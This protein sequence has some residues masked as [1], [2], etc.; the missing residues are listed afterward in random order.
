M[1]FLAFFS[2]KTV[3]MLMLKSSWDTYHSCS[4]SYGYIFNLYFWLG[5]NS[6]FNLGK[7]VGAIQF[8]HN[9]ITLGHVYKVVNKGY[10]H[11]WGGENVGYWSGNTHVS[12]ARSADRHKVRNASL[13]IYSWPPQ[14]IWTRRKGE[15]ELV[16][17][18]LYSKKLTIYS[19]MTKLGCV[20]THFTVCPF[21]C[22][23]KIIYIFNIQDG[24]TFEIGQFKVSTCALPWSCE[25]HNDS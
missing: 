5:E 24:S 2:T 17:S 22:R 10:Y 20:S 25:R 14:G 6:I 19:H 3:P 1:D 13:D 7:A 21:Q 9:G 15:T 23:H 11:F 18:L 4:K 12:Y 8:K 16:S